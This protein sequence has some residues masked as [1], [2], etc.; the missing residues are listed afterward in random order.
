MKG[1]QG[2]KPNFRKDLNAGILDELTEGG[3]VKNAVG[4]AG[5]VKELA[6]VTK[7]CGLPFNGYLGKIETPRPNGVIDEVVV[8]FEAN[9]P[10]KQDGIE[11]DVIKEFAAGSRLLLAGKIQTL[12]AFDS[13]RVLVFILADFAALSEKAMQQDD[14]ALMGEIARAPL[15]R[16]TPRGKRITDFYIKTENVLTHSS[17]YIPCICWQETADEVAGWQ[18]GDKVKLL[19]DTRAGSIAN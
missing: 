4:L 2:K 10:F 12:K 13:G 16:T 14:V 17:S 11:F 5:E 18:Q 9:T 7:I 3:K 6:A 8:A 15:Y 19:G 1:K